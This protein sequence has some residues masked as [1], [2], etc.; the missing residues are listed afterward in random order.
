MKHAEVYNNCFGSFFFKLK[1]VRLIMRDT[2]EHEIYAR[3]YAGNDMEQ[4]ELIFDS[5]TEN[6]GARVCIF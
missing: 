2:I 1:V 6:Y 5:V 3:N 4:L